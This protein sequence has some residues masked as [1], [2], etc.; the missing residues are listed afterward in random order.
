MTKKLLKPLYTNKKIYL[1]DETI[2]TPLKCA[3]EKIV[4]HL[5]RILEIFIHAQSPVR[6]I[7]KFLN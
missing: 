7:D 4:V 5:Q 2:N 6:C 3:K 1:H